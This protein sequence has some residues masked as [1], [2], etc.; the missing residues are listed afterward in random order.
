M[1]SCPWERDQVWRRRVSGWQGSSSSSPA[2]VWKVEVSWTLDWH[3]PVLRTGQE[4][5]PGDRWPQERVSGDWWP[6]VKVSAAPCHAGQW[7][8]ARSGL[9]TVMMSPAQLWHPLTQLTP[10]SCPVSEMLQSC[11]TGHCP[12]GGPQWRAGS[13][14]VV[15]AAVDDVVIVGFCCL[16]VPSE[17]QW[18]GVHLPAVVV[19]VADDVVVDV[20]AGQQHCSEA[21]SGREVWHPGLQWLGEHINFHHAPN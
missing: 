8:V 7:Q 3:R 10:P 17:K 6:Q 12:A 9:V 14:T 15:V 16:A 13:D 19:V 4:I 21:T 2:A 5:Y 11:H 18:H 1:I 20:A